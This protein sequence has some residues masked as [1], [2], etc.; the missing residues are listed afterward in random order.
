MKSK[1]W[2]ILCASLIF[3][4]NCSSKTVLNGLGGASSEIGF[5][6]ISESSIEYFTQNIGD[7]V[8]FSVDQSALGA[9]SIQVLREQASWLN[10][11]TGSPI[12]IEGHADEQGTREYNLALGAR[13][14]TAV[15][16]YLVS[17][18]VSEE[19]LSIVTYGKERPLE[20]C[21]EERCWSKNR[22]SVT[23]VSGGLGS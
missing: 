19:R 14:A 8:L 16:N 4:S 20:V 15:R 18:G 13:R 3:L 9:E 12:T 6:E 5:G 22:R 10:D 11:N 21:S 23:V 17:Q 7:T 2:M 1:K